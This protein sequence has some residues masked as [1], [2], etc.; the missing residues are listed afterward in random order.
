MTTIE[1]QKLTWLNGLIDA[2]NERLFIANGDHV[3]DVAT[4][5]D[6]DDVQT[7]G[8]WSGLQARLVGLAPSF[9]ATKILDT[10]AVDPAI[11]DGVLYIKTYRTPGDGTGL[12]NWTGE[13][14]TYTPTGDSTSLRS[15][16]NWTTDT[17]LDNINM[18]SRT[19]PD[20]L[21]WDSETKTYTGTVKIWYHGFRRFAYGGDGWTFTGWDNVDPPHV[22]HPY[23]WEGNGT[24][25]GRVVGDPFG[26]RMFTGHSSDDGVVHHGDIIEGPLFADIAT[27]LSLLTHTKETIA[28]PPCEPSQN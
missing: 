22:V 19:E 11:G 16:T 13:P 18:W 28:W 15:L 26:T 17:F 24:F 25:A 9:V 3:S 1:W 21:T 20:P 2:I 6:G 12:A 4:V 7:A 27:A 10:A 23:P 14:Y 5:V 8:F